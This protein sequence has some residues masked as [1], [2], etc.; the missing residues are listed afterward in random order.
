MGSC[1]NDILLYFTNSFQSHCYR[2][3]NIFTNTLKNLAD[4]DQIVEDKFLKIFLR[5]VK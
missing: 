3:T 4:Q 1:K 2:L 5:S